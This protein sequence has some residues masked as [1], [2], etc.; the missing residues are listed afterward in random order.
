LDVY[1][2]LDESVVMTTVV[3]VATIEQVDRPVIIILPSIAECEQLKP[4]F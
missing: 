4:K 3:E 2:N 1:G